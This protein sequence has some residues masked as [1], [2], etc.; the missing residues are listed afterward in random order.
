MKCV[1]AGM[2]AR[3]SMQAYEYAG[4]RGF[5]KFFRCMRMA[6][7]ICLITMDIPC[8]LFNKSTPQNSWS[9]GDGAWSQAR[10]WRRIS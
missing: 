4:E 6:S 9:L 5:M 2:I 3:A 10:R 8:F 1:F 7:S